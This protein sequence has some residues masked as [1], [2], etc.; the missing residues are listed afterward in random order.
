VWW[1]TWIPD[2]AA[3]MVTGVDPSTTLNP[4]IAP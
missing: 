1:P 2:S 4:V 3:R